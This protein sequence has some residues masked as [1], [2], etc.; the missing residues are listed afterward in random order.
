MV[1]TTGS[2]KTKGQESDVSGQVQP[3]EPSQ[4]MALNDN[5]QSLQS[6]ADKT[7]ES[8]LDK[9]IKESQDNRDRWLRAVAELENF[10]KRSLQDKTRLL[11][12]K[13]EDLLRELL[14]ILDNLERALTHGAKEDNSNPIT[15]GVKMV[16]GMFTE[17]LKKYGVSELES[18]GK[19]F[20]PQFHEAIAQEPTQDA[21]PNTVTKELEKGYMYKDKLLRP[22]KVVVS[23]VAQ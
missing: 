19:P 11:K 5:K 6:E 18:V 22:A 9:T 3:H 10:K 15:L 20:D 16:L 4:L 14:P 17:V 21:T 23:T 7:E 13:E 8:V 12:Y 2:D 1:G